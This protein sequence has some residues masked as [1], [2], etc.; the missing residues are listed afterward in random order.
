[1]WQSR[2]RHR[3]Q[4][5]QSCVSVAAIV[6]KKRRPPFLRIVTPKVPFL[7]LTMDQYLDGRRE[8][9]LKNL[10]CQQY[11]TVWMLTPATFTRY[12]TVHSPVPSHLQ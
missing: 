4:A 3:M 12:P 6:R 1:M 10:S 5:Q 11:C 9:G 8:G 2:D 7:M